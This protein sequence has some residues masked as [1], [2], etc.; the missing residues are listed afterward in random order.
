MAR[1]AEES[2]DF[3]DAVQALKQAPSLSSARRISDEFIK[4]DSPKQVNIADK[5][6]TSLLQTL[7]SF[8]DDVPPRK[9][10]LLFQEAEEEVIQAVR[11]RL[12]LL[13]F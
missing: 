3:Y 8:E 1:H 4:V 7:A 13:P 6:R 12:L 11:S 10:S 9:L 5:Q 2:L